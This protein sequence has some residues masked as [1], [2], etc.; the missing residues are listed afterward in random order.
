MTDT[1][2][3]KIRVVHPATGVTTTLA[4]TGRPGR[5]DAPA[6]FDEPAGITAADGKLYVAD[7]NNHLVRV[8]DLKDGRVSTLNLAGLTPPRPPEA[9]A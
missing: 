6:Q 5:S 9:S 8:I 7:T 4:G 2:N 3:N 1:Y